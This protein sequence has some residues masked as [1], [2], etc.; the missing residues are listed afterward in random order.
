[1]STTSKRYELGPESG[2][3][4]GDDPNPVTGRT[5]LRAYPGWEIREWSDGRFDGAE[6]DGDGLTVAADDFRAAVALVR[7]LAGPP[8]GTRP[9]RGRRGRRVTTVRTS[10]GWTGTRNAAGR[11]EDAPCCGC[12]TY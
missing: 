5:Q 11:C 1:M 8:T 3:A 6:I 2:I 10:S 12:C 4:P 7:E 9:A